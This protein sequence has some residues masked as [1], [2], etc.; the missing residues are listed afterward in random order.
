MVYTADMDLINQIEIDLYEMQIFS[1]EQRTLILTEIGISEFDIVQEGVINK[2]TTTVKNII[3]KIIKFIK[4]I[5]PNIKKSIKMTKELLKTKGMDLK[6]FTEKCYKAEMKNPDLRLTT[7]ECKNKGIEFI[8][9]FKAR[10]NTDYDIFFD[11]IDEVIKFYRLGKDENLDDTMDFDDK[12]AY[13]FK[14]CPKYHEISKNCNYDASNF[15]SYMFEKIHVID[16]DKANE[17]IVIGEECKPT[18]YIKYYKNN[19]EFVDSFNPF[20][21]AFE[22]WVEGFYLKKLDQ[23]RRNIDDLSFTDSKF[24][25][26]GT[27]LLS[28][29]EAVQYCLNENVKSYNLCLKA[30][31]MHIKNYN[32]I[33]NTYYNIKNKDDE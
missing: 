24:T 3:D 32:K 26:I 8:K 15:K 30:R 27:G 17:Y 12:M 31:N 13:V 23:T 29:L 19:E 9:N 14:E 1:I 6:K 33:I 22:E 10:Y 20:A 25:K 7:V 16:L 4:N 21:F 28:L 2:I 18:E 11:A 5:I